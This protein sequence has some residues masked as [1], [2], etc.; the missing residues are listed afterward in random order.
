MFDYK[1]GF[2]GLFFPLLLFI[3][4]VIIFLKFSEIKEIGNLFQKANFWWLLAAL[5]SQIVGFLLQ[6]WVYFRI[7]KLLDFHKFNFLKL[8]RAAVTIVFLNFT[9]PS[10]GFAGN[11]YFIRILK[12]HGFK[13][14]KGLLAIILEFVCFYLSF[15]LLLLL[16]FGLLFFKIHVLG[17]T[18]AYAILGFI[19]VLLLIGLVLKFSL[20]NKEKATKR[21]SWFAKKINYTTEDKKDIWIDELLTVFYQDV[22]SLKNKKMQVAQLIFFQFFRF[23]WDSVTIYILFLAFGQIAPISLVIIA[24]NIARLFGLLTFVP[25]GIG[26]FEG[27]MV[28]VFNSMGVQLELAF[29]VMMLYRFFSYWLYFPLGIIFYRQLGKEEHAFN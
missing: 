27:A 24:P 10:L 25:G 19:G 26:T 13:E 7:F 8:L 29:A 23:L 12:K 17:R 11:I 16:S 15:I 1:I 3:I 9:I 21:V 14:G 4:V 18:Q 22:S 28:L 20:G 2:K 5:G 6:G